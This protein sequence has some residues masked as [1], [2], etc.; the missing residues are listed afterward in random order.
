MRRLGNRADREHPLLLQGTSRTRDRG[1]GGLAHLP[2]DLGEETRGLGIR[3]PRGP[4]QAFVKRR[5]LGPWGRKNNKKVRRWRRTLGPNRICRQLK[6]E[7]P[8]PKTR[9]SGGASSAPSAHRSAERPLRTA[10]ASQTSLVS[11]TML[12]NRGQLPGSSLPVGRLPGRAEKFR[13]TRPAG[14][15]AEVTQGGRA[16]S[17][18]APRALG[19]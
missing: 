18:P 17:A 5:G 2:P 12:H 8:T 14:E 19:A 11:L 13:I 3:F 9:P 6:D 15:E 4:L 16:D 7:H 10:S 1:T